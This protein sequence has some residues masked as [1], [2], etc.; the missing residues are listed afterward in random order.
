MKIENGTFLRIEKY[1]DMSGVESTEKICKM[2]QD[3]RNNEGEKISINVEE[4]DGTDYEEL[5][6]WML[7]NE[8]KGDLF[9]S[10]ISIMK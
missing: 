6:Q 8:K 3:L 2:I 7:K 1:V 5:S 4:G 10:K 9:R